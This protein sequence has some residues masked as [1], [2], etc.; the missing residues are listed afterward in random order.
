MSPRKEA[1]K[2]AERLLKVADVIKKSGV[3]LSFET[4][5]NPAF[6]DLACNA[7]FHL[8]KA[9]K[10]P[11]HE[12]AKEIAGKIELPKNGLFEKIESDGGYVNFF[13]SYPKLAELAINAVGKEKEKYGAGKKAGKKIMVEYFHA[14]THKAFHIGHVRNVCLGEALCRILEFAGNAVVRVN[15]QGD[16]GPHVSKCVW[17]YMNFLKGKEP[18]EVYEK[19]RWLGEVYR[20]ANEM[21]E[22]NPEY[23][24]AVDKTDSD[25]YERKGEAAKIWKITRQWSLDYFDRIY[26]DFGVKFRRFY[27]ESEVEGPGR[28]IAREL[29]REGIARESEGAI[30]V[31]LEKWNLGVCIILKKDGKPLYSTKELALALL[32]EKE[33]K[34]DMIIHVVGSEQKLYFQQIFRIFELWKPDIAKRERHLSYELVNLPTGKMK[35]REGNVVLY[36]DLKEKLMGISAK[37]AKEKNPELKEKDIEKIAENVALGALKYGM[38]NQSPDKTIIFDWDKALD[39]SGNSAPY[40]QY[41]YTRASSIL[42][43]G[44]IKKIPG[45]DPDHA[46]NPEEKELV[47][48]ISQFPETVERAARDLRPHYVAGFCYSLAKAFA[49]FYER[50]PVLN[51]EKGEREFRMALVMAAM[52]VLEN[53]LRLLG[54]NVMERM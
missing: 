23:E 42:R 15:Y 13:Y 54:I 20:K 25:I 53:G 8:A 31:D 24:K 49:D 22:K 39:I 4:P 28:E 7:A 16:I 5:P 35:S 18:K 17:A 40:L 2:E 10:R 33:Y 1:L 45:F 11:P 37:Q 30:I 43:K 38:I 36:E 12:I 32:Q 9:L 47:K 41:S 34:T 3:E 46:K 29:L 27:F 14:N 19:G 48:L 44:G 52:Q 50:L 26:E 6:G 51:A 21:L